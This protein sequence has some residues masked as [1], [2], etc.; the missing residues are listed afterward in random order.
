MP[1]YLNTLPISY[2]NSYNYTVNLLLYNLFLGK[3]S[4]INTLEWLNNTYMFE[5]VPLFL[6]VRS[7]GRQ[8]S[9]RKKVASLPKCGHQFLSDSSR[10]DQTAAV[11]YRLDRLIDLKI[12]LVS[13]PSIPRQLW[14]MCVCKIFLQK[15]RNLKRRANGKRTYSRAR[16]VVKKRPTQPSVLFSPQGLFGNP[17]HFFFLSLIT[18]LITSSDLLPARQAFIFGKR[19]PYISPQLIPILKAPVSHS[20]SHHL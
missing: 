9:S 10:S 3:E 12:F 6:L 5:G 11:Q 2:R 14:C 17:D 16:S 20:S 8:N 19:I 18:S 15:K 7:Q 1:F 13:I 4:C